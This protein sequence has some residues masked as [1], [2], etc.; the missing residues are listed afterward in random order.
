M[1]DFTIS[2]ALVDYIPVLFFAVSAILLISNLY[3]KMS[4]YIF[5]ML[6][7]GTFY[8]FSAGFLK[9]TWKLL[10]AAG[11]CDFQ[12]LNML[13][14]PTQSI[15]F[16]LAGIAML[17]LICRKKKSVLAIAAP[18]IFS[19]S[20]IFLAMMVA[21]LGCV[22]TCLSIIAARMKKYSAIVLFIVAFV[23][24]MGMGYAGRLDTT[25][26]WV[27]WLEQGI[28]IVSQGC[29]MIGMFILN[30]ADLKNAD[31]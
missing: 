3:S 19:G 27:N 23:A 28:N 17:L 29:L 4:K 7:A 5:A 25:V 2:M 10:Y 14:L 8:V 20:M 11:V 22:C 24:S 16:L 15:G 21:G 18:P 1:Y 6:A 26:S 30:K 13:F 31:I 12:S 9:A